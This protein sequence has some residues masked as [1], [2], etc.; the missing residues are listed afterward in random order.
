LAFE[1]SDIDATVDE[2][3]AAGV[4]FLQYGGDLQTDKK[5]I[6]RNLPG[7]GPYAAWFVDPA[8]NILGVMQ[9]K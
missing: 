4:K 9:S 1:V 3:T 8:G 2:L 5:G 7:G 6:A